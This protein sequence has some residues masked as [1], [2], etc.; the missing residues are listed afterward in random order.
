MN[1][2]PHNL[3]TYNNSNQKFLIFISLYFLIW[4][5]APA[6]IS[7]SVPLDVSEGINWGHEWQWGYYKHPPFSS[8][9]LYSFYKV[10]GHF[11]PYLL[12]QIFI[13]LTL[14]IVYKLAN[15]IYSN[16]QAW[17]GTIL[18][19]AIIYYSYSSLEFNHN[20]AQFPIW[21]GLSLLFYNSV[22]SNKYRDWILLGIV[23][24]IGMLTKYSVAF[25]LI[26]MAL[27]LLHPKQWALL[28]Q[29]K[30]WVALA[31]MLLIFSPHLM[32]LTQHDWLPF[33]YASG[34]SAESIE[35]N[36]IAAHFNWINFLLAQILAHFPFLVILL[37]SRKHLN[38]KGSVAKTDNIKANADLKLIGYIWLAPIF[39]LIILSLVFGIGLR[40]MWGMPMWSLSGLIFAAFIKP[41]SLSLLATKIP[42]Y[43]KFWLTFVTILTLTYLQF[44]HS[45]RDKPSRMDWPEQQLS[46]EAQKTWNQLSSCE[47]DSLSGDRWLTALIAMNAEKSEFKNTANWPSL[48][49]NGPAQHSPWMSTERLQQHGTL[50]IELEKNSD[51]KQKQLHRLPLLNTISDTTLM[52]YDGTW[53]INW[54]KATSAEPLKVT[55]QA[56]IPEHCFKK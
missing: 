48:M 10:F 43:V 51:S 14:F 25:L 50:V 20:I 52:Q 36:S 41:E 49:I 1:N 30:P 6:L 4:S 27:Y 34:R 7:S 47:W 32:W 8:W 29:P 56:Y 11:G 33:S 19:L 45:I 16:T 46:F 28:K 9:V 2:K 26:P 53:E 38:F 22:T 35:Q 12:S 5:L 31:L 24:G 40:D 54:P 39:L 21:A 42:K 17:I 37:V 13:I 18:T 23:G 55:W 3:K 15:K 44:G